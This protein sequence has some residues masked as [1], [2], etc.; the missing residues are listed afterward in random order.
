[1]I[2]KIMLWYGRKNVFMQIVIYI[3]GLVILSSLKISSY[4]MLIYMLGFLIF[5]IASLLMIEH[6]KNK[7]FIHELE[8]MVELPKGRHE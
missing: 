8:D 1:M 4:A 3:I 5:G 7:Q 2:K 6:E